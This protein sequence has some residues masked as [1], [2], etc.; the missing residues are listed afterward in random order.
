MLYIA[1]TILLFLSLSYREPFYNPE[2]ELARPDNFPDHTG[3]RIFIEIEKILY[4]LVNTPSLRIDEKAYLEDFLNLIQSIPETTP[5]ST[6][7]YPKE[8]NSTVQNLQYVKQLLLQE[9]STLT[10]SNAAYI[11][12]K[13]S[14]Y[15]ITWLLKNIFT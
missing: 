11:P 7:L 15:Y 9:F 6:T 4:A 13:N 14:I 1:A 12:V 2:E 10:V 3:H 5:P 8:G